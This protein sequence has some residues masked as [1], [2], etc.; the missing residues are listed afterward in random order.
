MSTT[1][2]QPTVL[3]NTGKSLL[4]VVPGFSP[5]I[6]D[7][8]NNLL[9]EHEPQIIVFG[10][11]ANQHRDI[12]FFSDESI[13]YRY[14]GQIIKS[15]PLSTAPILQKLLP[16]TNQALGTNFNG[17]LVNRY[18]DG[19]KSIGAHSDD[20]KALDKSGRKMVAS[21]AYGATRKFRIR[22]RTTKKIVLDYPH[23]SGTLL[24]ME[25]EFQKEFTHEIPEEKKIH[26]SRISVTFRH[27]L[28]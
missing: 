22:D 20:E 12:G 5:N 18:V 6:F 10:K 14:S 1:H 3:I 25:G 23:Q 16:L 13:G 26:E 19:T 7:E 4:W 11:P 21:I 24:I 17:I 15:Q 8:L 9:F 27:H 28:E 2:I